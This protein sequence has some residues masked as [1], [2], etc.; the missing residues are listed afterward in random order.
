MP[1]KARKSVKGGNVRR[2]SNIDAMQ[3]QLKA[4]LNQMQ[5][6]GGIKRGGSDS[7]ESDEDS[8]ISF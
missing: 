1:N 7:E 6:A 2:P 5:K 3:M 8:D 4:R